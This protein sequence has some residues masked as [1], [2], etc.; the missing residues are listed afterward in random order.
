MRLSPVFFAARRGAA[1]FVVVE[2]TI[3]ISLPSQNLGVDQRKSP[4]WHARTDAGL[5]RRGSKISRFPVSP[6]RRAC[7]RPSTQA[8]SFMLAGRG[9]Q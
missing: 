9:C 7:A 8:V 2:A 3:K 1:V 4:S 6:A 5:A